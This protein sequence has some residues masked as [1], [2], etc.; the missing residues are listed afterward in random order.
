VTAVARGLVLGPLLVAL[1]AAIASSQSPP[2]IT[3]SGDIKAAAIGTDVMREGGGF[4]AV[5]LGGSSADVERAWGAPGQCRPQGGG[6]TYQYF[7]ASD[8]DDSALLLLV[9]MESG[10]V[11][12]ILATLLPHSRGRGPSLRTGR[13]VSLVAPLDDVVRVYG[14][15]PDPDARAWIYAAD[16]V[17]VLPSKGLVAG[18][19]V[20]RSGAPPAGLLR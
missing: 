11:D 1:L 19:A 14:T 17:A 16:G 18:I 12:G 2:C 13:G 7:I 5:N 9:Y 3:G 8:T 4:G 6:V 15:P 20:F 10:R